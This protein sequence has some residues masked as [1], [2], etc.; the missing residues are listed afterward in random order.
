VNQAIEG[1]IKMGEAR[2]AFAGQI[3]R[4]ADLSAERRELGERQ[5]VKA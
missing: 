2:P 3:V 4:W 1:P 5:E